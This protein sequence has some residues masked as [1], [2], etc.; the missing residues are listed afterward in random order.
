MI[1]L[2]VSAVLL[3]FAL[4]ATAQ[5]TLTMGGDVNFNKNLFKP[6]ASGF[7]MSG[8]TTPWS[9]YTQQIKSLINGTL[10]FANIETVV[11]DRTDLQP[12]SKAFVFQTHPEAIQHLADIGFNFMNLANNH[13]YDFG[14]Q[15]MAATLEAMAVIKTKS[16][17]LNYFGIGTKTQLLKPQLIK[18]NGYT[19]AVASL[20]IIDK[21]FKA[22]EDTVGLI[23]IWDT[24][25]YRQLVKTMK[26]T[27]AH[28]KILS[29]HFGTEGQVTLDGKQKE[30]Y[31]YALKNGDVDLIIGHHP[32][33]VRPI[34]KMGDK[35]IFYSLGNYFMLGSANITKKNG[36]AD[37][38]LFSKLH[39]VENGNGRLIPE[40]IELVPLTNTHSA[41]KPMAATLAQDRLAEFQ[42]LI[43]SQLG[44]DGLRFKIT[45]KGRGM[46]CLD[47]LKLESSRTA[48]AGN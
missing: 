48:C 22:T 47:N 15:G 2:Y 32:H 40:A 9:V 38:G 12:Q 10:N 26:S 1:K 25:Q 46:V 21:Q 18:A 42:N 31:E 44:N 23:H 8:S 16:P 45:S 30:Y 33:A 36:G 3:A 41:V 5:V 34:Q 14:H 19:I 35:Y 37:F 6:S 29:I 4:P 7:V 17:Q 39:L 13:S 43:D 11:S 28:Y 24:E 20:S 27:S